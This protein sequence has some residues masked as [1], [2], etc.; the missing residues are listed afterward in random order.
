MAAAMDIPG[1][2]RESVRRLNADADVDQRDSLDITSLHSPT[3]PQYAQ[4]VPSPTP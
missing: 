1:G 3:T 4:P 2:V